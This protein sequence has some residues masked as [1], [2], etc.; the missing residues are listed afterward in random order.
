MSNIIGRIVSGDFEDILIRQKVDEEI[1]MGDLLVAEAEESYSLLQVFD[2]TYGSQISDK[3]KNLIA[4]M[5]LEGHGEELDFT[6]PELSNYIIGHAKNLVTVKDQNNNETP[7][8]PKKLPGFFSEL[9]RIKEEDLKFMENQDRAEKN[10]RA[11]TTGKIRSGSKV[12]D[13]DVN[14]PGED[15]L[16]H[17]ILIP[18]STG[19]G[20]SNLVKVMIHDLLD[21]DYCGFLVIDPHGE[22][23]GEES[24]NPGLSDHPKSADYLSLYSPDPPA[25]ESSLIININQLRPS[26]LRNVMDLSDAQNEAIAAYFQDDEENWLENL[27][28]G[29]DIKGVRDST[30]SALQRKI[31]VYL[32]VSKENGDLNCEGMFRSEGGES[33]IDDILSDLEDSKAVVLDTSNLEDRVELLV[34]S[35]VANRIF[36]QYKNYKNSGDLDENPVIS[37][38]LEEA[39]R[40]IGENSMIRSGN[41]FEKIAREG[42]KFKIGL[43]AI[44][45]LPSVIPKEIL[46]NMNTKILLGMEMNTERKS[47]V[48]SA[49][50][51]LS[52]DERNI[53]SLDIGE[54]IITSTFTNFAVPIKIPLF[55]E[56]ITESDN[57]E[58]KY[59]D[60]DKGEEVRTEHLGINMED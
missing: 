25:G 22:Y 44:T 45:Q 40:V 2:L 53:A 50:Q 54:A 59:R 4:G 37:T 46:A 6:E 7:Y 17:H 60:E 13:V 49:S 58:D 36:N 11:L 41:V 18:A 1:E 38:V 55:E 32:S 23:Y 29:K 15:V 10:D 3:E 28:T 12:L 5:K 31:Y 27:V 52:K 39:P 51:D 56:T 26:D 24:S 34:G 30:L 14:L 16:R 43:T 9:R 8:S 21:E 33:T 35:M 48:D 42:R 57:D 20:K 47:L 19:K